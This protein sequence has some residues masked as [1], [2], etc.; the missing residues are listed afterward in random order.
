MGIVSAAEDLEDFQLLGIFQMPRWPFSV[1]VY[2]QYAGTIHVLKSILVHDR[3]FG[4]TC[5]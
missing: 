2:P 4:S 1:A 5:P 3:I